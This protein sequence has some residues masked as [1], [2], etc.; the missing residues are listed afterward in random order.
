MGETLVIT[1]SDFQE[2]KL[3]A[4]RILHESFSEMEIKAIKAIS[5]RDLLQVIRTLILN[6][7]RRDT[8]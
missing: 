5:T 8:S 1:K 3:S 7:E 4:L 2:G 6:L